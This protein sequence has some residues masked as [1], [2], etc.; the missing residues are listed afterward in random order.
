MPFRPSGTFGPAIAM[1]YPV[2]GMF[3]YSFTSIFQEARQVTKDRKMRKHRGLAPEDTVFF[4]PGRR[5][6][7]RRAV[8]ELSWLLQRGYAPK[9]SLELV[10]NHYQLSERERMALVHTASSRQERR[11]PLSFNALRGRELCIDGFNLL[12]TLESWLGGGIILRG[13]DGCYRD[14]ANVHG[15]Y[16]FREETQKAVEMAGRAFQQA[17]VK[18][19]LWL[20]DRPVSNSGRT[21][22]LINITAEAEGYPMRAETSDRVDETLKRSEK[23]VVTADSSIL[24]SA[25]EWF[26]LA[27]WLIEQNPGEGNIIDLAGEESG[28]G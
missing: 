22:G 11:A 19:G 14:I 7:L 27:G 10:G 28:T 21:A 9:A 5:R 26:D 18:E 24:D 4:D 12:I 8:S 1:F 3:F 15:S 20:F 17:G 23:V 2:Y 6:L 16:S 25:A 13:M